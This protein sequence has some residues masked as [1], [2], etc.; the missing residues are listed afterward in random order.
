MLR[1]YETTPNIYKD[2]P[3]DSHYFDT[4]DYIKDHQ[5][6]SV[7]NKNVIG[8]LKNECAGVPPSEFVGL[9]SRVIV[10]CILGKT[11]KQPK[12]LVEVC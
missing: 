2:M 6:Y 8:K 3:S 4:S 11:I 5:V 7:I 10:F 1:N 9:R 12:E